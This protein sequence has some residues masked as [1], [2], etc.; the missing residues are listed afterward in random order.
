MEILLV[1]VLY[2]E[3]KKRE[4]RRKSEHIKYDVIVIF[5]HFGLIL[6]QNILDFREF[7]VSSK[8]NNVFLRER[9]RF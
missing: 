5:Q 2:E 7:M 4:G 6:K 9:I 3:D 8:H 1:H